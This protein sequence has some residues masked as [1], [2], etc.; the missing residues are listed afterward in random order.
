MLRA[1]LAAC[2]IVVAAPAWAQKV[3]IAGIDCR[4][5][6]PHQPSADVAYKP[7]VD[8]RGR[9]VAP[10]DVNGAPQ[11][12]MPEVITFDAAVDLRRFGIPATSPLFQPN[13][14]VGRVDV[15][16]DGRIFFNGERLGSPEIAALEEL[17]SRAAK[18]AP[19]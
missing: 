1:C 7:G 4:K 14:S 13:V 15:L 16:R 10:A 8:A 11:I 5:L 17:C 9:P 12:R 2:L 18:T 3:T 6:I 19:K